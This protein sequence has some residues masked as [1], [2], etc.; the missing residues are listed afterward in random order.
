MPLSL[1]VV[2][3]A[4][5]RMPDHWFGRVVRETLLRAAPGLLS[6]RTALEVVCLDPRAMRRLN[7]AYRG[8]DAATDI[9]SFPGFSSRAA[10]L[11]SR[12]EP[13]FLG[14]LFV[15][16]DWV[17]A[18]AREDRVAAAHELA[19]VLSHGVLHLLGMRHGRRMFAIQDT[20]AA[21]YRGSRFTGTPSRSLEEH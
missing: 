4:P 1:A 10:L 5:L 19:F 6:R 7:R 17:K 21:P 12:E 2:R 8:R 3:E 13:L 11:R 18:G 14:Q 20:V 16:Y 15:C 9:L